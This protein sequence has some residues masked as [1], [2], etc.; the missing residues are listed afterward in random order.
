MRKN[1]SI[2]LKIHQLKKHLKTIIGNKVV[3]KMKTFLD[4]KNQS[5]YLNFST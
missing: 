4:R 3:E 5:R 2:N 1:Y